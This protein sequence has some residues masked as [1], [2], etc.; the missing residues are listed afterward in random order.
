[1]NIQK[2]SHKITIQKGTNMKRKCF[3][4]EENTEKPILAAGVLFIKEENGKKYVLM[5]K[6]IEKDKPDQYS[7]FGGKIDLKDDIIIDT[8]SRELGEELN[9]GLYEKVKKKNILFLNFTSR[10]WTY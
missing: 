2:M 7:D 10:H 6:V 1:M 8:I 4:Y 3:Y 5:Q 9:W